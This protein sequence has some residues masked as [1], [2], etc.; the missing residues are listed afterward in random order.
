MVL[1][2]GSNVDPYPDFVTRIIRQARIELASVVHISDPIAI[3]AFFVP[4]LV[5]NGATFDIPSPHFSVAV[6]PA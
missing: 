2:I 4:L 6:V 5:P 3:D 1:S